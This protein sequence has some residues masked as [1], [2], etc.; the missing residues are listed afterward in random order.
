MKAVGI[1]PRQA[2]TARMVELPM[3]QLDEIPNGRGVLV[4]ILQVG[5]DGTDKELHLG[6]YGHAPEGFDFLVSGHEFVWSGRGSGAKCDRVD[7]R[8]LRGGN[9]AAARPFHL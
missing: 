1:T 9:R 3:P 2:H 5:V 8:R 7:S 4:K 6:E